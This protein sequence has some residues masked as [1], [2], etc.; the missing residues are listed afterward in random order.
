MG[1][2]WTRK[3][4]RGRSECG[5]RGGGRNRIEGRRRR[6]GGVAIIRGS[7]ECLLQF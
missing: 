3:K 6:R 7:I 4:K 5:R 1:K 2:K